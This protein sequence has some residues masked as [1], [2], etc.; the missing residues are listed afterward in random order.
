MDITPQKQILSALAS[1]FEAERQEAYATLS[2]YINSP[3]AVAD[4]PNII[5]EA[6]NQVEKIT[7]AEGKLAIINS[8]LAPPEGS[9]NKGGGNV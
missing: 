9:E 4:H 1:R 5:G 2:L 6:A 7:A 8:I 3:V